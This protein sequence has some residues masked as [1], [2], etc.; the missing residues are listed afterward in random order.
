MATP[1]DIREEAGVRTL[2]FGSDWIQGAMRIARPWQLELDYTREM[3]TSL[4]LRDPAHY[5]R[6]VLLIGL[7]AA[8]RARRGSRG[9]A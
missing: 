2:H 9:C 1:I 4:I 8:S 5:P 7:G 3:M 6:K